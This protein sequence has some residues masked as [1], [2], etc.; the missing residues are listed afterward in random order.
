M[1]HAKIKSRFFAYNSL[2]KSSRDNMPIISSHPFHLHPEPLHLDRSGRP[3]SWK[4]PERKTDFNPLSH[5]PFHLDRSGRPILWKGP[6]RKTDFNPLSHE[7]F[8]LDRSGRPILWKG[9]GSQGNARR[10]NRAAGPEPGPNRS[11]RA[12]RRPPE[13]TVLP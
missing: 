11:A 6:Q 1:S 8:H 13:R 2:Q 10:A 4:G 7:P 9:P 12:R 5:E 3:I